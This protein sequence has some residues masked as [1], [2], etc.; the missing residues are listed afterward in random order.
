MRDWYWCNHCKTWQTLNV[1]HDCGKIVRL[2]AV[3]VEFHLKTE[4]NEPIRMATLEIKVAGLDGWHEVVREFTS[5]PSGYPTPTYELK[6]GSVVVEA[7]VIEKRRIR[8]NAGV[9]Q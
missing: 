7:V 9:V 8:Q 6:N 1:K 3:A 4:G 2:R 5:N